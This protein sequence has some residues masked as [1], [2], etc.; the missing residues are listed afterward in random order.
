M[1]KPAYVFIASI[2]TRY[3]LTG[4]GATPKQAI[5][6][7]IAV[8]DDFYGKHDDMGTWEEYR[9]TWGEGQ[10]PWPNLSGHIIKYKMGK[11]YDE[12]DGGEDWTQA[13][14]RW[15]NKWDAAQERRR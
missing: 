11:G 9:E 4:V 14:S 6:A 3:V 12:G 10:T 5:E 13:E 8:Y 1:T 7:L 2:Q 15:F